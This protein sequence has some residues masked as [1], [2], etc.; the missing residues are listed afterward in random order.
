MS[1]AP[2]NHTDY[3]ILLALADAERHGYGI[4][5]EVEERCGGRVRFG[6]GTLYGAL[7]RLIDQRLIEESPRRPKASADDVRRRC[8]YRLTTSGRKAAAAET[9]RLA[10]LVRVAEAKRLIARPRPSVEGGRP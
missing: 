5:Q 8:Y 3:L 6:P 2:L 7:R 10:D 4:M 9:E 1:D